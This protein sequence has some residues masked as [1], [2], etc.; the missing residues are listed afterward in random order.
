[1]LLGREGAAAD[2][3]IEFLERGGDRRA[4]VGIALR[5]LRL[6]LAVEAEHVVKNKHLTIAVRARTNPDGRDRKALRRKRP[7][8]SGDTLEHDR[9]GS[10]VLERER[11]LDESP[12]RT[13][14]LRLH[15]EAAELSDP[16]R[17]EADV[18]HD[19]DAVRGERA[20]GLDDLGASLDLDRVHARLLQEARRV[21]QGV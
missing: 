16:L 2:Y 21:A 6:E 14:G 18:C 1:M 4:D 13:R 5:E 10:G 9:E 12:R 3:A 7:N 17:R 11:V 20:D 19:S 15:L 8:G